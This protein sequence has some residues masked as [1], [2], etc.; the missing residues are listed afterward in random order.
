M[1]L[2]GLIRAYEQF[3]LQNSQNVGYIETLLQMGYNLTPAR[4]GNGE[5]TTEGG[6][7]Y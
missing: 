1:S 7:H 2:S 5:V 6:M 4:F 3:I